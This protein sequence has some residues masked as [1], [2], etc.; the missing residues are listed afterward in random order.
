MYHKTLNMHIFWLNNCAYKNLTLGNN[1]NGNV[2]KK[3]LTA[4]FF[5][6]AKG[7]HPNAQQ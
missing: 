3:Y 6:I 5:I 1:V 7:K 4:V 2:Y